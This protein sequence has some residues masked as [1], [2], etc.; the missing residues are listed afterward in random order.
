MLALAF[1]CKTGS[2]RHAPSEYELTKAV[3][4]ELDLLEPGA[5]SMEVLPIPYT[6]PGFATNQSTRELSWCLLYM[7]ER[8]LGKLEHGFAYQKA[9][10]LIPFLVSAETYLYGEDGRRLAARDTD[11]VGLYWPYPFL[12]LASFALETAETDVSQ[13][14]RWDFAVNFLR[15]PFFDTALLGFGSAK[16]DVLFLPLWR[17]DRSPPSGGT[18]AVPS[19]T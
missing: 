12:D 10:L 6:S 3:R 13:Q 1:G 19:G 5:R 16:L 14:S 2:F 17:K 15:L 7:R 9:S 11:V 8:E 18:P 4:E